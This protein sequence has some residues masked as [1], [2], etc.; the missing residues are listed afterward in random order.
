MFCLSTQDGSSVTCKGDSGAPLALEVQSTVQQQSFYKVIGV[1]HGSGTRCTNQTM[2]HPGLYSNVEKPQILNWI[3]KW[4]T[5]EP[6]FEAARSKEKDT[7]SSLLKYMSQF[8]P[9]DEDGLNLSDYFSLPDYVYF[10]YGLCKPLENVTLFYDDYSIPC[11]VGFCGREGT[12]HFKYLRKKLVSICVCKK[13]YQ[14]TSC[15]SCQKGYSKQGNI[16][17]I[18]AEGN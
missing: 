10:I 17:H 8:D 15:K 5:L 18:N 13:G 1:L 6:L 16:C 11:S 4:T 9:T 3:L 14:G 2:G 12:E 7:I